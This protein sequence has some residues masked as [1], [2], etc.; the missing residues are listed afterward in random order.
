MLKKGHHH[1]QLDA[2]AWDRLITWIDLNGPCHGTWGDVAP[3]PHGADHRRW[4]LAQR[5]G[6]PQKNPEDDRLLPP[7]QLGPPLPPSPNSNLQPGILAPKSMRAEPA[8]AGEAQRR[9]R[10]G[11]RWRQVVE[12]GGGLSLNLVRIPAGEFCMGSQ[13]GD[14]DEKPVTRVA[15]DRPIWMSDCEITNEQFRAFDAQHASGYFTKR[16]LTNDGPGI[17]MNGP[18]Q[19][20][21]RVSWER[22]L[23]FCSWLS[24]CSGLRFSLPTEAEWEYACR[25]GSRSEFSYG[26]LAA[27]FSP[28]ANMADQ[29]LNRLHTVTG[30]VVILLE[31]PHD[32]RYDDQGIATTD[33]GRYLPNAWGL[34][35]MHGNAAEWTLSADRPYPYQSLDGRNDL[36]S[37][38]RR[39]VRGGSYYDRPARCRSSFRLS[40]PAWQ[41]VHNVGFRVV[42]H[43]LVDGVR[44]ARKAEPNEG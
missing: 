38:E 8:D 6:G 43:E 26:G 1:V 34:Y 42:T 12:L 19:P 44:L 17:A 33:V 7:A 24:Q 29:A 28:Q 21:V 16:S 31:L 11:G 32:S 40:Y 20:V 25:A 10:D 13:D 37:G 9:Q 18:R 4:E 15:F 35:D 3:I 2:E 5:Y 36:A 22:A 23:E 30:G 14:P 27:D 39:I 41:R